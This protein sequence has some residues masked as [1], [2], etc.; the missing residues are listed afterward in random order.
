MRPKYPPLLS[1]KSRMA[2]EGP[3]REGPPLPFDRSITSLVVS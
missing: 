3:P 1:P 2:Q